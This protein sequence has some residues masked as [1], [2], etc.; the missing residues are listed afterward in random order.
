MTIKRLILST[1]FP[2]ILAFLFLAAPACAAD[3]TDKVIGIA[4]DW[5]LGFQ[6]AATPVKENMEAFHNGLLTPIITVISAFVMFLLLFVML[7][8]NSRA[9]PTP[10][11]TTH[12][13]MLEIVWTLVPVIIL[14]IIVIPS[15]KLLYYADRTHEAE[16]TLNITGN[17]WNWSYEYPDHGGVSFTSNLVQE[18]DLKEGQIRLLSTDNPV[19]LPV[20]TNIRLLIT[21]ADV[22]HSWAVPSFGVKLDAVP[23][24]HNETWARIEKE[25]TFFGQCSE[26]C[27]DGHGF[28]PI[29]IRAV[30]K[31]E[32]AKWIHAQ[33]G[34]MPDE[35]AASGAANAAAPKKQDNKA[36]KADAEPAGEE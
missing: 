35:L 19:V 3:G 33:G 25:G 36:P 22:L 32:F 27:G 24:K 1:V 15:M 5:Q 21:A 29:E 7:R 12:N 9:N 11:K 2:A 31:A 8:F 16:M 26:L 10:S 13:T 17:Q 6:P 34:K 23:G 18:A 28:M 30:P 20:D 4:Q 14:V